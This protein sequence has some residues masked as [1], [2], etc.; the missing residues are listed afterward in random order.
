MPK[1]AI[2]DRSMLY[3]DATASGMPEFL[4]IYPHAGSN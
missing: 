4:R 3:A 2:P 1:S